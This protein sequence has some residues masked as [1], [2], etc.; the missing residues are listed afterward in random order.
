MTLRNQRRLAA[1]ILKCGSDKV[2]MDP[3]KLTEIG[4]A[5]TRADVRRLIK[6]GYVVRSR[7]NEQSRGR[8]RVLRQKKL[9]GRRSGPGSRKGA[10]YAGTTKKIEWMKTIRPLRLRLS[11][12]R[13]VDALQQG[14][15]R[16]L[17]RMS[18]AGA[19]RSTSHL[20]LYI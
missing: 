16:K 7:T 8:A 6:R 2:W 5:I 4:Q 9:R 3:T 15:Y 20:N 19:F 18:K 11:E 10:A 12:L 1:A 13:D 17:Y 14:A